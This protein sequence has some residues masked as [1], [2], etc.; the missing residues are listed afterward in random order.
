[1]AAPS[2]SLG[3]VG[4]IAFNTDTPLQRTGRYAFQF[5]S[6]WFYNIIGFGQRA[7]PALVAELSR[8]A[9][10]EMRA[11]EGLAQNQPQRNDK[12]GDNQQRCRD[13]G[14]PAGEA[15][16]LRLRHHLPRR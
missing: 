5:V 16:G 6:H 8:Y 7:V 2:S 11:A 15:G 14:S 9:V 3:A 1:M 10:S 13:L 12:G 4:A